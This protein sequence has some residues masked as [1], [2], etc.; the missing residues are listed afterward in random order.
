MNVFI[1]VGRFRWRRYTDSYRINPCQRKGNIL[2]FFCSH[3]CYILPCL[4]HSKSMCYVLLRFVSRKYIQAAVWKKHIGDAVCLFFFW[5]RAGKYCFV[6]TVCLIF[7]VHLSPT[8]RYT[9]KPGRK[10]AT[11]L[12]YDH[13]ADQLTGAAP[14]C[15]RR[16]EKAGSLT[17]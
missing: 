14:G 4:E 3:F 15:P 11:A 12:H 17:N 13:P 8:F 7:T 2:Y 1:T 6:T 10:R 5:E 9:R 16:A